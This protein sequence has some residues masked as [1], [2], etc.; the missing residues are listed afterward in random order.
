MVRK[1]KKS[2]FFST[3]FPKERYSKRCEKYGERDKESFLFLVSQSLAI[4]KAVSDI[5]YIVG[6]FEAE[7]M[8]SIFTPYYFFFFFVL[9]SYEKTAS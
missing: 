2:N 1:K 6:N 9:F 7:E 5:G 8:K 4:R 3:I